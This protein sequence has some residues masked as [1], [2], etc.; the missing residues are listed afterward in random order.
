M[1]VFKLL[2]A[3]LNNY[4]SRVLAVTK[5]KIMQETLLFFSS[6]FLF[7]LPFCFFFFLCEN[8]P[9]Y[10]VC[11]ITRILSKPFPKNGFQVSHKDL[12]RTRNRVLILK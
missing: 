11:A 5:I 4:A 3:T 6:P 7:L 10:S 8:S 2:P 1:L 9:A 12:P